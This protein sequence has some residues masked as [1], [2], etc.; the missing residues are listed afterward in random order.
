MATGYIFIIMGR[1][2]PGHG[3]GHHTAAGPEFCAVGTPSKDDTN[4][5]VTMDFF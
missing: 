4:F 2:V 1:A 5:A 3:F